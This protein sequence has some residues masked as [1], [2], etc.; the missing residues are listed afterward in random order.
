MIAEPTGEATRFALRQSARG[1]HE[2][3]TIRLADEAP[4]PI[5]VLDAAAKSLVGLVESQQLLI[6]ARVR[7]GRLVGRWLR[8]DD[9]GR[10]V[11][12]G[13]LV[14]SCAG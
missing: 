8:R 1:L 12:S 4:A 11:A 10:I 6:D 3:L 5:R 2:G 13:A 9:G 14:A 7:S